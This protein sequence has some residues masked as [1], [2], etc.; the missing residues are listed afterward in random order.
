MSVKKN[1]SN[2][3]A[4]LALAFEIATRLFKS[5]VNV[6]FSYINRGLH[7]ALVDSAKLYCYKNFFSSRV[8]HIY[9]GIPESKYD[10]DSKYIIEFADHPL[11][12]INSW[13]EKSLPY[14]K[15]HGYRDNINRI[16]QNHDGCKYLFWSKKSQATFTKLFPGLSNQDSFVIKPFFSP[17]FQDKITQTNKSRFNFLVLASNNSS[18]FASFINYGKF[19]QTQNVKI[20]SPEN[21]EITGAATHTCHYKIGRLSLL[22]KKELYDWADITI[23]LSLTDGVLPFESLSYG[24]PCVTTPTLAVHDYT[25]QFSYA[26]AT[27]LPCIDDVFDNPSIYNWNNGDEYISYLRKEHNFDNEITSRIDE[28]LY[29]L[30]KTLKSA[31]VDTEAFYTNELSALTRKSK[32]DAIYDRV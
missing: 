13:Y 16:F 24:V 21:L 30:T 32:L 20:V 22:Q 15:L 28:Q 31:R 4:K 25:T 10:A 2:E 5:N 27:G 1:S 18:K 26:S 6:S 29:D 23:N 11:S 17:K 9:N 7:P 14:K 12:I 3:S 8:H 19:L